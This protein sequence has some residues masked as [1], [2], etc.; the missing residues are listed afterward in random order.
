ML[1]KSQARLFFLIATCGFSAVFLLLTV[2]T[3]YRVDGRSN[4]DQMT[5]S[6]VRGKNIWEH[7]NCMGCHT[8]LGEGAYYAPELTRSFVRRGEPWL[9][10]FLK[11]PQAMYPGRRKMVQYDFTDDEIT[12]VIAFLEWIGNIDT[13]G[14]PREPDMRPA[15]S[16]VPAARAAAPAKAAAPPAP[17]GPAPKPVAA[18]PAAPPPPVELPVVASAEPAVAPAAP[19]PP[20]AAAPVA[21]APVAAPVASAPAAVGLPT[22]TMFSAVCI[23]CH[24]YG[25][26]GGN[27]GPILDQ[28]GSRYDP[29]TLRAWLADPQTIKPGT[30]MPNLNLSDAQLDELTAFL[31]A[32]K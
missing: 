2:D 26:A 9:R 20:V 15:G 3:I 21:A 4:R 22:P 18:A 19:A 28:V 16:V 23:G 25:G 5:E 13:N 30:S 24:S 14:F 32:S 31:M 29:A 10:I 6:V 11:D 7:N 8:I 12:D 27:V 1:S 17:A